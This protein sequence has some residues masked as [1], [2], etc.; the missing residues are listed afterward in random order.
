MF[1]ERWG[2]IR[3][4]DWGSGIGD[5]GLGNS[6]FGFGRLRLDGGCEGGWWGKK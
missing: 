6:D 1:G 3:D 2:E 4:W 5:L